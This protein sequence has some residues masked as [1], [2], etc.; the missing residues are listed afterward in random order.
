MKVL[1][2]C[3][4]F[5]GSKV[6]SNLYYQLDRIGVEQIVYTYFRN[7]EN[8][9]KNC[10]D[11]H[12]TI[13]IY[14]TV[15]KPKHRILYHQKI[16]AVYGDLL[17]NIKPEEITLSHA[18]TL[19]SD[20]AIAYKLYKKYGIPY[21]V[22]VRKTDISEFMAVAPHTWQMGVNVLKNASKICF[23]SKAPKEKFCKHFLI[24]RILGEIEG[25]FVIQPNGIDN[26]WLNNIRTDRPANNKQILYVGKFDIN[27]NVLR[28]I[29][30]VV[31]LQ[32]KYPDISLHLVGG[33]GERERA[34]VERVKKH[35]DILVYH[36]PVYDKD[37]LKEIYS[38][39]SIFAMPS[40]HETFGLVYIEALSQGLAVLFTK[41]QG[42]DGLLDSLV[43][44]SVN[45]FST[46]SISDALSKMIDGRENYNTIEMVDYKQFSWDI[47]AERYAKIYKSV[48]SRI[49]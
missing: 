7:R 14:S 18:T 40:I 25:K 13:F 8:V 26:Y 47:I 11:A 38:G 48:G 31:S 37:A 43:G 32:K 33:G 6:H 45:A 42:I 15:L 23:I 44:E 36:G 16:S 39:C 29:D 19:F 24:K 1:H 27:K 20:G 22:T 41:G 9:G 46:K 49:K 21:V 2:I 3:N 34:V 28:L 30:A 12:N 17:K 5:T 35:S 4:D 10:F